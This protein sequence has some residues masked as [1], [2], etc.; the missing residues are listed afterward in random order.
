MQAAFGYSRGSCSSWRPC[1]TCATSSAAPR[2][3]SG[4]TWLIWTALSL[5]VFRIAVGERATWSLAL[6]AGQAL[7]AARLFAL[8]IRHGVGGVTPLE[9]ALL[10]SP[11][12]ASPAGRSPATRGGDVPRSW[13]PNLIAVAAHAPQDL[14]A[15]GSETLAT[16][17]IG[18]VSDALRPGRG[19]PT[20]RC[21]HC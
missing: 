16:Y 17:A 21:G 11:R 9:L 2:S 4:R 6:T 13:P 19:Q 3:R 12:S 18:V 10:A 5:V 7:A 1:R 8:A 15:P 14:P 20:Q